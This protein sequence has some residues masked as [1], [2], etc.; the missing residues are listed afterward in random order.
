MH[1]LRRAALILVPWLIVIAIWYAIAYS[2][3]INPSLVPTPHHVAARF[4]QL[5]TKARLPGGVK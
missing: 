5:L 2:G 3:L 4:W 1:L